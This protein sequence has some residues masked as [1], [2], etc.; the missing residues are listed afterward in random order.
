VPGK[1]L[2]EEWD[3]VPGARGCTPQAC[4]FRDRHQELTQRE[5]VIYGL[6]TQS[7]EYQREMAERNHLPFEIVSD[8][9][10][11]VCD[12]L[13]L[14]TFTIAEIR[15]LKRLTMIVKGGEVEQVFY[16]KAHPIED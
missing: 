9:D 8:S 3:L 12:A 2:P 13:R 11:R 15:L 10:F 7:A 6:S 4:N 1:P 16:P 5:V 14:P